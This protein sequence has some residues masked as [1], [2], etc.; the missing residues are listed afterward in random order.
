MN[1]E[2]SIDGRAVPVRLERDGDAWVVNGRPASVIEVEPG[3]YSV[4][5]DH[6][7]FEVRIERAGES[8]AVSLNGRRVLADVADPRRLTRR[9]CA[10]DRQGRQ[11]VTAPMPGKVVRLLVAEGAEVKPGQGLLVIEA[12]KMQNEMKAPKTG[13]VVSLPVHE[14]GTVAAGEVLAVVE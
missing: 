8:W 4:L 2:V 10:L 9:G 7:S 13:R 3:I 12:M 11:S 14:G 1:F 6:R 5:L